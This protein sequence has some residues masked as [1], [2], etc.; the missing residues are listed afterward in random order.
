[1]FSDWASTHLVTAPSHTNTQLSL[2]EASRILTSEDTYSVIV[3]IVKHVPAPGG[4]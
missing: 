1:M 3:Y 4:Q 2:K